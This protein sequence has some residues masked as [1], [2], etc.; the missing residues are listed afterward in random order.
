MLIL[1]ANKAITNGRLTYDTYYQALT[2]AL[3]V[4]QLLLR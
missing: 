4:Y 1:I 3:Y 2:Q